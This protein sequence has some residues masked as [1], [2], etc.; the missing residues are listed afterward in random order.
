VI[1]QPAHRTLGE[2]LDA[3]AGRQAPAAGL[4]F[5][6]DGGE[7]ASLSWAELAEVS[8]RAAGGFTRLGVRHGDRVL[9]QLANCAEA[10]TAWFALARLGAIHV[11]ANPALTVRELA[12]A[13]LDSGATVAVARSENAG[14]VADAGVERIVLVDE[15][16]FAELAAGAPLADPPA[17][18]PGTPVELVYTSGVTAMPKAAVITHANCVYSGWS[19]AAAMELTDG[20]RVLS[21]LPVFHV[22]AQSALLAALTAGASL[23]LLER[24][25][26]SR[27]CGQ[28]AAHGATV[29]SLVGTQVR[30]LLRQEPGPDDR[31][32]AT[33]RA[34]FSLNVTDG[35]RAAFEQ[36]FG[37]RLLN[38][39]GLT[40]AFTSVTQ[41]PLHGPDCWPAVGAPLPGRTLQIAAAE[42][43]VGEILVGGEPGR[44]LMAGYW[45]APDATGAA[46]RDGWLHT[47]DL[48]RLDER[49]FLH[50]VERKALTIKRAGENVG[51]GEVEAVLLEHPDVAEAAVVGVPDPI[52]DEAVKAVVVLA[53]AAAATVE[54]LESW[55]AE[56]LAPFK[57][58][59]VWSVR[60]ELPRSSLGKVEYRRLRQEAG[61]PAEVA[62]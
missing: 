41:A 22:N 31:A 27:Y 1:E 60:D 39:Y 23:V 12:H 49:G 4:T 13:V 47:G 40:E 36:R 62:S 38:G 46:L 5:A 48:G 51:A 26:A 50:F 25:S 20:D 35:E 21:A 54:E 52:R 34:W 2:L 33:T 56:R 57:V 32:H 7:T 19:K 15:G 30:T 29:T 43:E 59:T 55:C 28:L 18:E 53:P 8:L 14:T 45:R 3:A 44:T 37:I 24:Y 58:P 10:V 16:S 9:V 17:L 6:A 61:E 42:G 11:P